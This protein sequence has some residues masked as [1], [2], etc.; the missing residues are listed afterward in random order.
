MKRTMTGLALIFIIMIIACGKKTEGPQQ[1]AQL[2]IDVGM[3][4]V[5]P[6]RIAANYEAIG[7]VQSKTTTTLSSKVMGHITAIHVRAGDSVRSGQALIEIDD[8]DAKAQ[9]AK[10]Q[11]GLREA[12]EALEEMEQT[13][14]AT[15]AAKEA[16]DANRTLAQSTY[17]RYKDLL[18]RRSVSQQEFEEVEAKNKVAEAEWERAGKLLDALSAKRKQILAGIDQARAEVSQTQVYT[19]YTRLTSPMNGIVTQRGAEPGM[20]AAPGIPLLT[21][22]DQSHYRLEVSVEES[23]TKNI[24]VGTPARIE[25]DAMGLKDLSAQVSEIVPAIDPSSRTYFVR[26]DLPDAGKTKNRRPVRS[27]LFGKASF[28][29]GEKSTLLV[30]QQSIMRRGQLV[31]VYV[32]DEGGLVRTRLIQTGQSYGDRVEVISGLRNGEKIVVQGIEKV[33][34]GSRVQ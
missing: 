6:S 29:I 12:L 9:L 10:A 2:V 19:S 27:G 11:A 13:I 30:P 17:H 1:A 18:E 7:T 15:E 28:R 16:A 3:E 21:I 20:L 23:Q 5:E 22:E 4:T 24:R 33:S 14:R 25:I 8:R 34:E 31:S 26:I 32:V